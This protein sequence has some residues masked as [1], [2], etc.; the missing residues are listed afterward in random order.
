MSQELV[1]ELFRQALWLALLLCAPPLGVALVV[2]TVVSLIQ[3]LTQIQEMT[4][5]F[6]PKALAVGATLWV[7]GGWMLTQWSAWTE[8][9]MKLAEQVGRL[10]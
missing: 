5:S 10:P 7:G 1:L 4:L 8:S 9:L 3:A 6:V 2:G